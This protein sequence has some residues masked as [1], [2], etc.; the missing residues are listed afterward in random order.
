MN[1]SKKLSFANKILLWLIICCLIVMS[2]VLFQRST[3][4][5]GEITIE[6]HGDFYNTEELYHGTPKDTKKSA[7]LSYT[8]STVDSFVFLRVSA[9]HWNFEETTSC[10]SIVNGQVHWNVDSDWTYLLT[11]G[12]EQI[13]Y[14]FVPKNSILEKIPIIAD[15][16]VKVA[17]DINSTQYH[18]T[19]REG[20]MYARF[21]AVAVK[22]TEKQ[23]DEYTRAHAAWDSMGK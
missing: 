12:T 18:L 10:Y 13:F 4:K 1:K 7:T 16:I 21:S 15:D 3:G 2:V 5:V 9:E 11:E 17:V 20:M 23:G 22:E 6:N 8:D 19:A 14:L